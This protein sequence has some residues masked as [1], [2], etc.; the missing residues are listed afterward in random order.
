MALQLKHVSKFYKFGKN[1]QIVIDDLSINFPRTGM[2]AIVGKSG[3]GKSTLLNLIAGIEKTDNGK[4]MIDGHELNFRQINEY[5][6][7]YIS[8]VYQFYNLVEALT[9]YENLILL[10]K[11]KGKKISMTRL[12]S[13]TNKL[14]ITSLLE[15]YP[16]KLSGGQKQRVSLIR[17]FLCDTPILLAD[18]PTGAL[19]NHMAIEV[20][21]LL[22]WYAKK[23]LV[24]IISHNHDLV[25]KYT[26]MIV[27]LDSNQNNYDFNH[28]NNYHKYFFQLINNKVIKIGFYVKR[29]L[30]YQRRKIMMMFCSQIFSI[31]AF[32][33]LLSG[34]NGGWLYLQTCFNSNP[35]KEIVEVSK[36]DYHEMNF[37]V[38]QINNLKKDKLI[39]QLS[40][41][42]DFNLGTFK[43]NQDL[44]LNSYQIYKSDNIDY[45]KG[46]YFNQ[47]NQVIIN[48]ETAKTYHL[49]VF[50]K[51]DF[52]VDEKKYTLI[53][54]AIINDYVNSGTNIYYDEEY[55]D[56]NLKN[57]LVDKKN[58]V[59][60]SGYFKQILKK[61]DHEYFIT[62][63]HHDYLDGYHT[64]FEMAIIVVIGFLIVSF[65][66]SLILISIILKMIL[67]ERKR[68][69][70][71]MLSNGLSLNKARKIFSQETSLIGA[72]I[73]GLG[74]ILSEGLLQIIKLFK[75]SD[76]LLNIPDLFV[77]PR[78][79]LSHYDLYILMVLIYMAA[80]FIVGM[81]TSTKIRKMD[82]SVLLK[83]D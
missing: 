6:S 23:H 1:K 55:L 52:I 8:Y 11:I 34:I 24:I 31:C 32:V 48:Q 67:I 65:I 36:K 7:K 46:N 33:L 4:I 2:V 25:I 50:D 21:E 61:Y 20:M 30:I 63:L 9:V 68:D 29:Q 18:E 28:Q 81:V 17:A 47:E 64:L 70:C 14:A 5:Q 62:N 53:V 66:I 57:E 3:S 10:A 41:K 60:K 72:L 43:T 26:K 49:N 51:I 56:L 22:K 15:Y 37:T 77:L 38:E 13:L 79:V 35:L 54:N 75:V 78:L 82:T 45:Q 83:E 19:N 80:C 58:L 12:H 27:N 73:G 74:S 39:D 59:I 69:V 40:Y 16:K 42:L 76:K 71:L 44:Q